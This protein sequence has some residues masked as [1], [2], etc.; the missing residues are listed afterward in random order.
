MGDDTEGRKCGA[1][2]GQ[3]LSDA[4]GCGSNVAGTGVLYVSL[5][6]FPRGDADVV[7]AYF[8]KV[9]SG[10]GTAIKD[11]VAQ[12]AGAMQKQKL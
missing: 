2:H 7:V 10:L 9:D 5:A 4:A 12:R 8:S 1:I 6:I 11:G 3:H